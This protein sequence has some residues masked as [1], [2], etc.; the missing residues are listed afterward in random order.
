MTTTAALPRSPWPR[1]LKALRAARGWTQ[2][3]AADTIGVTR[4]A[5][6]YWEHDRQVPSRPIRN[7][8]DRIIAESS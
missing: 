4:R 6:Q 1:R 3:Q 8:L 7:L 5:W 2:Q